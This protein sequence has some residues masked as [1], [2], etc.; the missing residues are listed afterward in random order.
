LDISW[1]DTEHPFL[2][3]GHRWASAEHYYQASKFKQNNPEF[4]LSFSVESGTPLSKNVEMAKDAASKNGKYKG[5]L[6]RP[7]EVVMDPDFIG[8]RDQQAMYNAQYAKF[9]QNEA[10][11]HTL[12]E[13]KNAKLMHYKKGKYP[14]LAEDLMMIRDKIKSV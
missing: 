14:E 1:L 4:Y 12:L 13:T 8:K 5:E 11:K 9:S 10:L 6:I 2:L 3:D 7:L